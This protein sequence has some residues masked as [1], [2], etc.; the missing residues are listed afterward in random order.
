MITGEYTVIRLA[1]ADDALELKRLYDPSCPRSALLDRRREITYP[2][3]HELREGLARKDKPS[4]ALYAV[5]DKTGQIRGFC[6]LR[7]AAPELA[8]GEVILPLFAQ[9][10]YESPLAAEVMDYLC[11]LAFAD[12]RLNKIISH[13]LDHEGAYRELLIQKGFGSNGIQRDVVWAAGR[14]HHVET[15][16]RFSGNR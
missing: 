9:E 6:A 11:R 16:T 10:D 7:G 12:K 15:L 14:Y 13:C 3:V 4:G 2:T 8:Y 5:E 1:E